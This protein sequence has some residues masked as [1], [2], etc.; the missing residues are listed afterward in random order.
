M[1]LYD[2]VT[3]NDMNKLQK[4]YQLRIEKLPTEYQ[5]TWR[6]LNQEIWKFSDFTGR[7]LYPILEGIVGLFEESAAEGLSIEAVTGD[8]IENFISEIAHIEG[9]KTYRDKLRDQLNKNVKKKVGR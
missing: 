9:A 2:K 6:T 5:N 3:G 4:E 7:N 8:R 1:N